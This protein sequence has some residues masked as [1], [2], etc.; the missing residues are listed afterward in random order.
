MQRLR[1]RRSAAHLDNN[2]TVLQLHLAPMQLL[3]FL[4]SIQLHSR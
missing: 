1:R 3:H 2:N 4:S